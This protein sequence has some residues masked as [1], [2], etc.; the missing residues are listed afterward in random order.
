MTHKEIRE[1]ERLWTSEKEHY[2]LFCSS[3]SGSIEHCS[4]YDKRTGCVLVVE[5]AELW[6][7]VKTRM[8]DAGVPIVREVPESSS[9]E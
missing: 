8:N 2:L 6:H 5:D 3:A 4:I 9:D 1:L 7:A